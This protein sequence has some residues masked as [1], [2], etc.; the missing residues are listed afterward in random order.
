MEDEDLD[1]V[2]AQAIFGEQQGARSALMEICDRILDG[3]QLTDRATQS[4]VWALAT[5]AKGKDPA[6]FLSPSLPVKKPGAPRVGGGPLTQLV[7]GL[8]LAKVRMEGFKDNSLARAD[9]IDGTSSYLEAARRL[10]YQGKDLIKAGERFAKR[11]VDAKIA[12]KRKTGK[13]AEKPSSRGKGK[14]VGE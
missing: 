13:P 10:G 1:R 3:R 4:L 14:P 6:R 8:M 11:T 7:E 12:A 5:I 9:D 2:L